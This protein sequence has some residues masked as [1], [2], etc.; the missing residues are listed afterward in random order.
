MATPQL[1]SCVQEPLALLVPLGADSRVRLSLRAHSFLP[2]LQ[3]EASGG[4]KEINLIN[5]RSV[6]LSCL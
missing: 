2:M 4:E 6:R 1:A 3:Q 5:Q